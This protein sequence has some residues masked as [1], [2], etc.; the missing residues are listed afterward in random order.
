MAYVTE[1]DIFVYDPL[2]IQ[3]CGRRPHARGDILQHVY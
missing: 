2:T 3:V 1:I